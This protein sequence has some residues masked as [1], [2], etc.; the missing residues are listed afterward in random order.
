LYRC[1]GILYHKIA[2]YVAEIVFYIAEIASGSSFAEIAFLIAQAYVASRIERLGAGVEYH[3]QEIN[4][5][6]APL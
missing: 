1:N 3:F 2:F 4:E 5:P 6:Y